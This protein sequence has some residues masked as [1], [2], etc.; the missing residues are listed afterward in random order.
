MAANHCPGVTSTCV[1]TELEGGTMTDH[2]W[3]S[4]GAA[5]AGGISWKR[6]FTVT[7]EDEELV[8]V[9]LN[10][11][12]YPWATEVGPTARRR[13]VTGAAALAP[14]IPA[15]RTAAVKRAIR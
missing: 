12:G 10:W 8:A 4:T 6:T 14:G 1:D 7:V 3:K 13:T 11:S 15:K 5:G 9:A 2:L